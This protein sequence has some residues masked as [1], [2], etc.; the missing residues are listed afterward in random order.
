MLPLDD[1]S[2]ELLKRLA[3]AS[4][5]SLCLAAIAFIVILIM[6]PRASS[7]RHA[8]WTIVLCG[9]LALP[10]LP[11]V[12]PR[13]SFRVLA[14]QQSRQQQMNMSSLSNG[15]PKSSGAISG[16][17]WTQPAGGPRWLL[18]LAA[19][20]LSIT[21]AFF[22]RFLI[23]YRLSRR[24]LAR[25]EKVAE[26]RAA[27]LLQDLAAAAGLCYPLPDLR[28]SAAVSVPL[29][30]GWK[31]PAVILPRNWTE[32]DGWKLR[33][34]LVHELAHI[35]RGDWLVTMAAC[36]GRCVFWFH[37]LAW[38][39]ERHLATLAEQ[40]SDDAA[41]ESTGDAA[42]YASTILEFA[43]ALQAGGH[44]VTQYGVAMARSARVGRRIERVLEL[45]QPD[46]G[47]VKRSA[48][49]AI[50]ASALP[51]MYGAAAFQ[52]EP[53]A[54]E[55]S[56]AQRESDDLNKRMMTE[57]FNLPATQASELERRLAQ[58]PEDLE[59][60]VGLIGYYLVN[61][62]P[63]KRLE[64]ILWL[65][66]HHPES[67]LALSL[68]AR[69]APIDGPDNNPADFERAKTSW[70]AQAAAHTDDARVLAHAGDFLWESDP[71]VADELYTRAR[72]VQPSN[73]FLTNRQAESV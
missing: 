54:A 31:E 47:F 66:E 33:A 16:I 13:V 71:F 51:F 26:S 70:M 12:V 6:R 48:W 20:Y 29:T 67:D 17:P 64:N 53:R 5:R 49:I 41:L 10:I 30:I 43:S 39:L 19:L 42:R 8:V 36:V 18:A 38:W 25:S 59:A 37:P 63:Q 9:M 3:D 14:R 34:V 72:Q 68:Q 15:A 69:L 21:T 45:R 50:L 22:V 4:W 60:R 55:R 2:L 52:V 58:N 61:G 11:A 7:A 73:A 44:R 1:W 27:Y 28:F 46:S 57:L 32:W 23:G 56:K 62:M 35:R 40:S 24:L 65:I